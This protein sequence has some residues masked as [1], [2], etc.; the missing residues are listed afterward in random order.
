MG[1][2]V[3]EYSGKKCFLECGGRVEVATDGFGLW[4]PLGKDVCGVLILINSVELSEWC[5]I[6]GRD[7]EGRRSPAPGCTTPQVGDAGIF[8]KEGDRGGEGCGD[9]WVCV[10]RLDRKTFW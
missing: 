3:Y 1:A 7:G 6:D 4:V 2:R 9:H 10:R 8:I 5:R